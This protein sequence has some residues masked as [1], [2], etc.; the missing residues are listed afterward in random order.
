MSLIYGSDS[1]LSDDFSEASSLG[2][3]S[4]FSKAWYLEVVWRVFYASFEMLSRFCPTR[5]GELFCSVVL[6]C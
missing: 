3:Q 1:W 5:F 6:G 4:S 2:F